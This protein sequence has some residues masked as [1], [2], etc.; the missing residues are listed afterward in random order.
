[1][2][3][4]EE[5]LELY[6]NKY[7]QYKT[8]YWKEY[9]KKNGTGSAPTAA[10]PLAA[11]ATT[12]PL[13]PLMAGTTT[14]AAAGTASTTTVPSMWSSLTSKSYKRAL[15]DSVYSH[16]KNSVSAKEFRSYLRRAVGVDAAQALES[17]PKWFAV[18]LYAWLARACTSLGPDDVND[19]YWRLLAATSAFSVLWHLQSVVNAT[20]VWSAAVD[21]V[22]VGVSGIALAAFAKPYAAA[23]G[24]SGSGGNDEMKPTWA[25]AVLKKLATIM[26]AAAVLVLACAG[27]LFVPSWFQPACSTIVVVGSYCI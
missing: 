15:G 1:M 26:M 14:T 16:W 21:A 13:A 3:F 6:K 24:S 5:A 18:L 12:A 17:T 7:A 9:E 22:W 4:S 2:S 27:G 19:G 25:F 8:L 10:A 20:D 23:S 11:A